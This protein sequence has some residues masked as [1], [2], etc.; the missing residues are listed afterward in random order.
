MLRNAT[1]SK[2]VNQFN[3]AYGIE[4]KTTFE[5]YHRPSGGRRSLEKPD[6]VGGCFIP[7]DMY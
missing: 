3:Y 7:D 6:N 4:D 5:I 2:E 1:N